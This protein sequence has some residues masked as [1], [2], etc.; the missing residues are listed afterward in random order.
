MAKINYEFG[1]KVCRGD[2]ANVGL[3]H[4]YVK[5]DGSPLYWIMAVTED[6]GAFDRSKSKVFVD[7]SLLRRSENNSGFREIKGPKDIVEMVKDAYIQEAM[8][9]K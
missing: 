6:G 1:E 4:V 2:P 5:G 9:R 3:E 8:L 7:T